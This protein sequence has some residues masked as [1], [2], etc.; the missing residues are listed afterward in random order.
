MKAVL[1]AGGEGRRLRP[2]TYYIQK[3]MIPIGPKQRPLLE[4][5]L[6]HIAYHGIRDVVITVGYKSEQIINYFEDGG[7]LGLHIDY[8]Y[9]K[10]GVIGSGHALSNVFENGL[11]GVDDTLLVYYGD[12]LSNL[13]LSE[14]MSRHRQARADATLAV[15]LK[16]QLP[17]GVVEVD[18]N[19]KIT[20]LHE[21]P[22]L[23]RPV[24]IGITLLEGRCIK[25]L[26]SLTSSQRD[27][28]I[29]SH[30]IPRLIQRGYNVQAY[31]S[32]AFWYDVGSTEKYEKLTTDTI[33]RYLNHLEELV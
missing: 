18:N 31:E 10:E 20:R 15:S 32:Q 3:C 9:D 30:F 26:S 5:I 8:V 2:L 7:R 23:D 12:I 28:D 21:K 33:S 19:G 27:V 29:M 1:M 6:R 25:E 14:M 24:I 13:D 11:I 16:Y 22:Y 17:V 4:Y